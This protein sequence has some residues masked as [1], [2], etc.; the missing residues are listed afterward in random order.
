MTTNYIKNTF[1]VKDL[2]F[3]SFEKSIKIFSSVIFVSYV[4]GFICWNIYLG[5]FG[6]FEYN[7]LETRYISAGLLFLFIFLL[8]FIFFYYLIAILSL[9]IRGM[10]SLFIYAMIQLL[11]LFK[12]E[13]NSLA[14]RGHNYIKENRYEVIY[15]KRDIVAIFLL[16]LIILI[17][18]FNNI[19]VK[20]PQYLG[21]A[22][23]FTAS[24]I[25]NGEQIKYLQNFNIGSYANEDI[26]PVQTQPICVL[27]QSKDHF[28][29]GVLQ[30]IDSKDNMIGVWR[31]G[32]RRVLL[33]SKELAGNLQT[34]GGAV[35]E[36]DC[37]NIKFTDT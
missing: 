21:G 32:G 22:R 35:S 27:Y 9:V 16:T 2:V 10:I 11:V 15:A 17:F 37:S 8:L 29:I 3:N 33:I 36:I 7:L 5:K 18:Y 31:G 23:P 24:I 19:F 34:R 26:D 6:F 14:E 25:G 30:I 12:K 20:I 4:V 28:I 13:N 1:K